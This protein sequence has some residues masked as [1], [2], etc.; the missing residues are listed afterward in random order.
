MLFLVTQEKAIISVRRE[1]FDIGLG[2][3]FVERPPDPAKHYVLF[4]AWILDIHHPRGIMIKSASKDPI[5][6]GARVFVPWEYV[7]GIAWHEVFDKM[8][9]FFGLQPT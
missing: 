8:E 5:K 1:W 9:Q 3:A 6:E 7:C 2:G 4:E